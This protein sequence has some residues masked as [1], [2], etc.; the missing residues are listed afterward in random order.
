MTERNYPCE[1]CDTTLEQEEKRVTLTLPRNDKLYV[2]EDVPARVCPNCGHRYY[3]GPMITHLEQMIR[4]NTLQGAKP[5]EAYK[6]PY[7]AVGS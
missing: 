2:F 6:I 3:H 1:F 5:I 7:E 4:E